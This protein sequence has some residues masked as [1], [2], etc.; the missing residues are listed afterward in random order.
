MK[1]METDKDIG[2]YPSND[3]DPTKALLESD[4]HVAVNVMRTHEIGKAPCIPPVGVDLEFMKVSNNRGTNDK[5][6]PGGW[7]SIR[8]SSVD[9]MQQGSHDCP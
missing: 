2:A 3:W 1:A 5:N 4:V 9:S 7:Q 6:I 8:I